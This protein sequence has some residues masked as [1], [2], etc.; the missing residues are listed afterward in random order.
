[1]SEREPTLRLITGQTALVGYGSL[2]S[3]SSLEGTLGRSYTGLFLQCTVRGWRRTWDAAMPNRK[4]YA[5]GVEGRITPRAILY[6]NVK[7]DPSTD[8]NGILFVVNQDELAAYDRRESIYERVDVRS[9]LD[10]KIEGGQIYM[11]VCRPEYCIAH[12]HSPADAAVRATYLQII[13]QGLLDFDQEF[14]QH[15]EKSTDIPPAH[16]IIDDRVE[17]QSA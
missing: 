16:L 8:I 13:E 4:F 15:Y 6:L 17:S 3:R 2:L 14:R 7:R 10:V 11:Y 9:D 1:M 12:S 5:E